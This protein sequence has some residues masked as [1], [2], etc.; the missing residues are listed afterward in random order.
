[1][2]RLKPAKQYLR[3]FYQIPEA[4]VAYSETDIMFAVKYLNQL[5]GRLAKPMVILVGLGTTYGPHNGGTPLG[6][7]LADVAGINGIV[8]VAPTGNEGNGRRHF[9]GQVLTGQSQQVEINVGRGEKG[10]ILELWGNNPDVYT[11]EIVS[12]SGERIP[13]IP[14]YLDGSSEVRFVFEPTRITVDYSLVETVSGKFL[15]TMRFVQPTEG[16]W[17]IFVYGNSVLRG[18][19]NMW[20]PIGSFLSSDTY[21]LNS[22]PDITLTSPGAGEQVLTVS[23]YDHYNNSV[24]LRSGRGFNS[25]GAVKPDIAAPGV[26]VYGPVRGDRFSRR[27]GSSIAAAHAAGCSALLLEW[28]ILDKNQRYMNTASVKNYLIKGADRSQTRMYPDRYWGYGTLNI[29]NVFES[30]R[31]Q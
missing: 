23:A 26:N 31:T 10:F 21:F 13:R 17:R 4:A 25:D 5:A 27:S 1:M 11:V 8:V 24:D 2:V 9:E 15:I 12:P 29:Y 30:L 22:N 18:T 7:Y 19:Y 6:S 20:L 28:G 16:V 3:D 14:A